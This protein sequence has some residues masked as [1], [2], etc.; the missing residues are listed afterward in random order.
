MKTTRVTSIAAAMLLAAGVTAGAEQT[1]A[2]G[3][4]AQGQMQKQQRT[5]TGTNQ[6]GQQGQQGTTGQRGDTPGAYMQV[7][8]AQGTIESLDRPNGK[9][10]VNLTN[11]QQVQLNL[12]TAALQAFNEGDR[13]TVVTE[14]AMAE[15]G[16]TGTGTD[17]GSGSR[18]GA[19]SGAAQG[20]G[21]QR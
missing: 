11:G 16:R 20:S 14:L 13:V 9:V 21:A 8:R 15:A 6:P 3:A 18:T 2:T 17:T 4:G 19:Q 7:A 5:A 12:P 10:S 1:G